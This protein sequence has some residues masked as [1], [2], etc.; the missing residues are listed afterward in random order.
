M[1]GPGAGVAAAALLLAPMGLWAQQPAAP[2]E[3]HMMSAQA[4]APFD[5][6]GYWVSMIT[7]DWLFRMVV[8][9][10]GQYT[11]VPITLKAK[12][13]ADTWQPGPDEAAGKQCEAYGAAVIMQVPEQLHITWQDPGTLKV[14]IDAGMQTRLLLFQAKPALAHAPPSRQGYSVA[15]WMLYRTGQAPAR[16]R[17]IPPP[18]AQQRANAPAAPPEPHYGWLRVSTTDMLAGLLRKNGVPYSGQT[19]MSEN[20]VVTEADGDQ[21]L[22]VTTILNDPEYLSQP[23]VENA[24]FKKEPNGSQ[25]DPTACTLD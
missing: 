10:R 5:P 23:Y 18:G 22:T 2:H 1:K 19:R 14:Q 9:Q 11:D 7:H 25:W 6:T 21:W 17:A 16:Q 20:W 8:P 15:Q 4:E 3:I 13:F 12:E 24:T